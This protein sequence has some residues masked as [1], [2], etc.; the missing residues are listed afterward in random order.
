[1]TELLCA[2]GCVKTDGTT[3]HEAT[4]GNYCTRCW[5]KLDTALNLA[6]ELAVHLIGNHLTG[7]T[8]GGE[9]VD[10]SKDAPVP[11]NRGAFDDVN[12]LYSALAYWAGVW[13]KTLEQEPPAVAQRAWKTDT[14][15]IVGLPAN[16]TA[17]QA[18]ALI[19]DLARWIRNRLDN[20]LALKERDDIDAFSDTISD[21]WR[22]NARWPR[23]EKPSYAPTPCPLPGCGAKVA[24]FPPAFPGDAR[25]IVCDKGH[26]FPEDEYDKH[27][28]WYREAQKDRIR[29]IKTA[30]RLAKKYS[31]GAQHAS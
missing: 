12:E 21:V 24:I 14:G 8:G 26:W 2:N 13:A 11:F 20:I 7:T 4:H 28:A 10:A 22:M 17:Q 18:G 29:A 27:E 1:M 31:I 3:P 30:Q 16:T 15:T 19:G 5:G 25:R 23:I 9:P 6:P